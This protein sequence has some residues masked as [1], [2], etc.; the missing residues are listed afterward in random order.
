[1]ATLSNPQTTIQKLN[2]GLS[3]GTVEGAVPFDYNYTQRLTHGINMKTQLNNSY[4][5]R[6]RL[7]GK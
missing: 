4:V 1:M 5:T 7:G 2:N 3:P 6:L